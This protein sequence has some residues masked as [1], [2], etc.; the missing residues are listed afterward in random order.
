MLKLLCIYGL[1]TMYTTAYQRKEEKGKST[2]KQ[3]AY[4]Q[5]LFPRLFTEFTDSDYL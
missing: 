5:Q 2:N 1:L 4:S 3:I